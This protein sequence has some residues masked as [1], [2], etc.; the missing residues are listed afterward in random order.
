MDLLG[1]IS[2]LSEEQGLEPV[3]T[4]TKFL[5]RT[6]ET[7]FEEMVSF[8]IVEKGLMM[9]SSDI[10]LCIYVAMTLGVVMMI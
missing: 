10:N 8:Q 5:R 7:N 2:D 1:D 6:N 4:S 3:A 9:H